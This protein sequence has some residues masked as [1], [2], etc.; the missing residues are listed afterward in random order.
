MAKL[1]ILISATN[2]ASGPIGAVTKALHGLDGV[3]KAAVLGVSAAATGVVTS[4]VGAIGLGTKKA[5]DLEQNVADIASVMGTTFDEAKPLSDLIA[6][7]GMDP[8]LK[9]DAQGAADAIMQLAQNGLGMADILDGAARSSVLLSNA[10]GGDMATSAA[11]AT[12]AMSLF[13]IKAKDMITAVN[14]ITG[15]TVASKFGIQDYQLA[16]AAAGGVASAVGVNFDDFN[17]TIT[18]ISSYFASGSDA[19][20]SYKTFLQRLVPQS[21][22][23]TAAMQQLGII[24]ADGNN[25][26]FDAGG[27]MRSMAEIAGILQQ[28]TAGLS[29][30]QQ[31]AAY[32]V[33]FGSDAMRAAF[34]IAKTGTDGFNKLAGSLK[35]VD[36]AASAATRMNTF[37]SVVEILMGLIDGLLLKIGN[38]FLPVLRELADWAVAFVDANGDKLVQWFANLAGWV[39]AVTPLALSWGQVFLGAIQEIWDWING[40]ATSFESLNML[41]SALANVVGTALASIVRFVQEHLP[42]WI[43]TLASWAAAAWQWV[44]NVTPE[45]LA[46]LGQLTL[47]LITWIATNLPTWVANLAA[48][49]AATWQWIVDVTP[50][51][52][53]KLGEWGGALYNWLVINL[54][55]WVANLATWAAAIWQWI[56][57]VTP[58]VLTKLG[59]WGGALYNWLVTNMPTWVANLATWAAAIWQWIVDVTPT[60]LT[61]L[62]EWGGALYNWLAANL[63]TWVAKLAAW[64]GAAW[65]WIVAVTPAVIAKLGEWGGGLINW[66]A[67]N[68]PGWIGKLGEWGG[69]LLQWLVSVAPSVLGKFGELLWSL[70]SALIA[71]L[72][73]WAA[74][75]GT[76]ASALLQWVVSVA[77]TVLS[78]LGELVMGIISAITTNLPAW[79]AQWGQWAHNAWEWIV[80]IT[81]TIGA[82]LRDL[83]DNTIKPWLD[84]HGNGLGTSLDEWAAKFSGFLATVKAGWD[85]AWPDITKV[86]EDSKNKIV[87]D[88]GAVGQNLNDLITLITGDKTGNAAKTWRDVFVGMVTVASWFATNAIEQL[89]N[90][91]SGLVIIVEGVKALG[92]GDADLMREVNDKIIALA[93]QMHSKDS[94]ILGWVGSLFSQ[95]F[96]GLTPRALGGPVERGGRYW[97]GDGGEPEMFVPNEDGTIVPSSSMTTYNTWNVNLAGGAGAQNDV[98]SAVGLLQ[99]LYG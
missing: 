58:T 43:A 86:L 77:P 17:T 49:A 78:K 11:V 33:M 87:A 93:T 69:A 31:N 92:T 65:Q 24:T 5:G 46:K 70:V 74:N 20:T 19:G 63:P 3:A 51:V 28:A 14:G 45:V 99:A 98:L 40:Q 10:T 8:K 85:L 18:A 88:L 15:V 54:P 75:L 29:E 12:D 56:V 57:D 25:R 35:K 39:K 62:G 83:W 71:S 44:V 1:D 91:T 26:F 94:E 48:W 38:A 61:K 82:K 67:A 81:P 73:G 80:D 36:A 47:A 16:L 53:T 9:V 37:N 4:V 68:L 32:T 60:V 41:W 59:E 96:S 72:P 84:E 30:E 76:W 52:L 2:D 95:E 66:L 13:G 23:A 79:T 97:V 90:F 89:K 27:N 64:A 42:D 21:K 55:T 7:L 22:E 50:T 34:G 6:D